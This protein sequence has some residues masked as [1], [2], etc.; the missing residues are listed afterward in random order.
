MRPSD[1]KLAPEAVEILT[2]A[3]AEDRVGLGEVYDKLGLT[4]C[5]RVITTLTGS[6]LAIADDM[7]ERHEEI[8]V[9]IVI[10][11]LG[12]HVAAYNEGTEG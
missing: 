9:P 2:L 12:Q 3:H 11:S 7:A 10:Q 4:D 1:Y 6:W 8:T 5:L